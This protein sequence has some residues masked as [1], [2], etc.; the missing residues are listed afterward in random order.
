MGMSH[1]VVVALDVKA[2]H[3]KNPDCP[4][5]I[6]RHPHGHWYCVDCGLAIIVKRI[7]A[8]TECGG[9][10]FVFECPKCGTELKERPVQYTDGSDSR[11][12]EPYCPKCNGEETNAKN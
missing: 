4:M 8:D 11:E 1:L 2:T 7:G 12:L 6:A 9:L 5:R 10:E 3:E